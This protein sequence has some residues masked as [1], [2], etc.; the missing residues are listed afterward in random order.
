MRMFLAAILAVPVLLLVYVGSLVR[1][2]IGRFPIAIIVV[3]MVAVLATD[4][5]RPT[6]ATG[7]PPTHGSAVAASEFTTA[8]ETGRSVRAA[9]VVSFP[10]P[11]NRAS[12][13]ALLSVDPI[14]QVSL[15]WDATMT[16]LR[17]APRS[18]WA[19]GT[20]YTITVEAGA[21]D[22]AGR[23][24]AHRI[25][26]SFLAR[27]PAAATISAAPLIG[28]VAAAGTRFRVAFNVPVDPATIALDISPAVT[29]HLVP[30]IG[31]ESSAPV[32][33]FVPDVALGA[34]VTYHVA[35]AATARD[36]AGFAIVASPALIRTAEAP[37]VLRF[38]PVAGATGVGWSQDLSVRFTKP[39]DHATTQAAWGATQAGKPIAGTFSWSESDTVLI[40]KPNANLGAAQKITIS[41]GSGATSR[42]G[43][44][45][46]AALS[47][48]FTTAA[49]TAVTV[50]SGS[51]GTATTSG[52]SIGGS[53]W[54]A[55]EAYY[56]GL[57]NCT[58]TGGWVT[59]TGACSNPGGRNVAPL[60]QDAGITAKVSRP[61][62]RKLVLANV[63]S[64]FYGSTPPDRLR[65]AGYPS[66]TWAENLGCPSGSPY[67]AVLATHL[68]FQ[69][70]KPYNGG[71]YVNLMNA[72]YDRVGIGV[73]VSG[74]RLRIVI[75]FYHPL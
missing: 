17:V 69:S 72:K 52:G 36:V 45:V 58:R 59:S 12:V 40:F 19:I 11:M 28:G 23:P 39:M 75:D 18:T 65:A 5:V 20:L 54:A 3:G 25:R 2:P 32:L 44:P 51:A 27:G 46:T 7:T 47:A 30:S 6:P 38:R 63:C 15:A 49:R 10:S 26:A 41:V 1:R 13:E 34:N 66:Y 73:W 16:H 43:L 67:A 55:V 31:S 61:Y 37:A 4:A 9:I 56:L 33:E 68:F 50:R 62:A 8:I 71:H 24:L 74:G 53:T 70:E 21:L 35:L 42:A 57:M 14:A 48:T 60:W 64:H 22:A 29:G